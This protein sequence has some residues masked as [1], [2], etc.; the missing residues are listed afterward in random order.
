MC[1]DVINTKDQFMSDIIRKS[2]ENKELSSFIY[3]FKC[4]ACRLEFVVFSW[5]ANWT[6]RFTPSC[7][8]CRKQEA[9]LLYKKSSDKPI[10][11]L[12]YDE[13]I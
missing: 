7:P 2:T 3:H 4:Q 8:E 10:L 6:D 1:R 12:Q 9:A 5:E 13:N 11:K